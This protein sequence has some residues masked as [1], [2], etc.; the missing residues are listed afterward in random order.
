VALNSRN[1]IVNRIGVKGNA[2][3]FERIVVSKP[4]ESS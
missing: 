3:K 2:G 4:D 1:L